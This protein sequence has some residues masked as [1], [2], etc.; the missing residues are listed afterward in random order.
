MTPIAIAA[1]CGVL[2]S[3][4][5]TWDAVP[6]PSGAVVLEVPFAQIDTLCGSHS[7]ASSVVMTQANRSMG[8]VVFTTL[9]AEYGCAYKASGVAYVPTWKTWPGTRACWLETRRHEEAH[10]KGYVHPN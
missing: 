9:K 8:A 6:L 4:P 1:M 10:L 7:G 3:P 5:A 2:Y